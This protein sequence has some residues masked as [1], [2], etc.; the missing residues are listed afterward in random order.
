MPVADRA[1]RPL[2]T[3]QRSRNQD[4]NHEERVVRRRSSSLENPSPA[5]VVWVAELLHSKRLGPAAKEFQASHS[6]VKRVLQLEFGYLHGT[7]IHIA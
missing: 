4:E 6:L 2:Q 5:T 1:A 3:F 7:Q